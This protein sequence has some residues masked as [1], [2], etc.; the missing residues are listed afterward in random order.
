MS[1]SSLVTKLSIFLV[2]LYCSIDRVSGDISQ[3]SDGCHEPKPRDRTDLPL[4]KW[5]EHYFD[6][7]DT[8]EEENRSLDPETEYA[9]FVGDSLTEGF[10]LQVHFPQFPTVNRGIVSD[11]LCEYPGGSLNRGLANRLCESVFNC[12]PGIIFLL[13]GTNDLPSKDVPL[14]YWVEAYEE[15][16]DNIKEESPEA[17]VVLHTLPPTG[18]AY[19]RHAFLNPRIEMFNL[20]IKKIAKERSLPLIDLYELLIDEEGLLKKEYTLDGLH[21]KKEHYTLWAHHARPY[22]IDKY[23]IPD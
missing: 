9:L 21:I 2:L 16:L 13:M 12:Q 18:T 1:I 14:S 10:P 17:Q 6:R 3:T 11:G 8:F 15:I 4:G 20:E 23:G 19:K 5:T 22:L 7:I